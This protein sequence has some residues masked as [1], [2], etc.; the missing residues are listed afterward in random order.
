LRKALTNLGEAPG[1]TR[2]DLEEDFIRF[3]RK[4][5]LPMPELNVP[6]RVG[7][8]PIEADCMWR[9]RKVIVE[10]DG[11]DAHDS[12]PA[13]ES[14]RARDLALTAAGWRPGRVTS[15]R[16]RFDASALAKEIRALLARVVARTALH[17]HP[18]V[19]REAVVGLRAFAQREH[20]A[21]PVR[22]QALEAAGIA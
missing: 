15:R 22:H 2:S 14:D 4:H 9:E 5:R 16:M 13:F 8:I 21:A 3:L 10:L 1:R 17:R 7:G 20:R 19:L 12:T 11:R 18:R 6:M